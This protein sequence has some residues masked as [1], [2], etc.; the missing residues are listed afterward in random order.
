MH[1]MLCISLLVVLGC[2]DIPPASYPTTPPPYEATLAPLGNGDVIEVVIY[3]GSKEVKASFRLGP[4]GKIAVQYIGD[5]IAINKKPDEL[6]DEIQKRLADGYLVDPIVSV[7]VT[8]VN[9]LSL[10]ISGEIAQDGKIKFTPGMTIVDAIALSGGFT[11]MAKKNHVKVIRHV[12]GRERTYKIPVDAI[13]TGERPNFYVAAGDRV[14]VP[15][16]L[17]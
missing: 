14:Y 3:N 8:E 15:E 12:D 4:T 11:P 1:Q 2:S 10:S 9:S 17:W 7:N 13:Q 16:R 6:K 5:V